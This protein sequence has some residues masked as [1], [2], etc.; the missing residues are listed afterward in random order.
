MRANLNYYQPTSCGFD[1]LVD[2]FLTRLTPADRPPRLRKDFC[3]NVV[4]SNAMIAAGAKLLAD[5]QF[6]SDLRDRYDQR[7]V[8]A[9]Q[10][11]G[12]FAVGCD[13][14]LSWAVFR[15]ISDFGDPHKHDRWEYLAAG[16]AALCLRNFLEH[17]YLPL[18]P[19]PL[20][21]AR[22]GHNSVANRDIRRRRQR[23]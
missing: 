15:G 9:D 4:S 6:L 16:C 12:G 20:T 7:M 21:S 10:E 17:E 11:S 3:P 1:E 19:H 14:R 5:G 23:R 8:A 22:T 13:A 2:G 18:P